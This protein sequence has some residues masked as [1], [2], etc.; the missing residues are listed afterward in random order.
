MPKRPYDVVHKIDLSTPN[1]NTFRT[2]R[3][4]GMSI[5]PLT[6]EH[7]L[8]I[9]R[10]RFNAT[11]TYMHTISRVDV[12]FPV[13]PDHPLHLQFCAQ[14]ELDGYTLFTKLGMGVVPLSDVLD[15]DMGMIIFAHAAPKGMSRV[16]VEECMLT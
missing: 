4:C 7:K 16:E 9:L 1:L 10:M 14:L 6:D 12:P 8:K 15:G 11:E 13:Y 5:P 2:H 3:A